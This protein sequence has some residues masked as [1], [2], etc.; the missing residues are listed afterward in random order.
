VNAHGHWL[1]DKIGAGIETD[2]AETDSWCAWLV[3]GE[4]MVYAYPWRV[5]MTSGKQS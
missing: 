5:R 3:I 1:T 4:R 2:P